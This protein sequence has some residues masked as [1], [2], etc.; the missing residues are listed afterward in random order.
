MQNSLVKYNI[1][2][3]IKDLFNQ[4]MKS[5]W[6]WL[7]YILTPVLTSLTIITPSLID[8]ETHVK[9]NT[10]VEENNI[11]EVIHKEFK[12][13]QLIT[14]ASPSALEQQIIQEISLCFL[15]KLPQQQ[16][17]SQEQLEI[18]S[19]E[20]FYQVV[21]IAPDGTIRP[22][23]EARLKAIIRF[24]G[25]SLPQPQ[26]QGQANIELQKISDSQI[27]TIP[28]QIQ[29]ETRNFL[30]DTGATNSILDNSLIQTLGLNS[31][32]IPNNLLE[33]MVVGNSCEEINASITS[34]P[35][36][37]IDA[38]MVEGLTGLGFPQKSIPGN[39]S[40]VLGMDFLSKFDIILNPET[41]SVQLLPPSSQINNKAIPLQGKLGLMT[42]QAKINNQGP[43]TFL[44]DTGA[45]IVVLS[46]KLA[47]KIEIN[48]SSSQNVQIRGFCGTEPATQV[49]LKQV[50][51]E[52]H[53]VNNIR[54]VVTD[55]EV[56]EFLG[57]DG[58]IGQN[59]LNKYQQHWQFSRPNELGFSESGSLLLSPL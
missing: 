1:K 7:N 14:Q 50:S 33:Y 26:S 35:Q 52:N 42:V 24:T 10:D 27:F 23:S 56:L 28:V 19:N 2:K 3:I 4:K 47:K 25:I 51:L 40:G 55:T 49:I 44:L 15:E 13:P 46:D 11:Q 36:V 38:A 32:P 9:K 54:G 30:F 37:T 16:Q 8:A 57:V 45:E 5:S 31:T 20:C 29:G 34:L 21:L 6:N 22:D 53:H 12:N 43:F 18:A 17:I 58:I 59:F 48:N 39:V 41:L